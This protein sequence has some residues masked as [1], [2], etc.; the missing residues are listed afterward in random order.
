MGLDLLN[1]ADL[2]RFLCWLKKNLLHA[3]FSLQISIPSF[4][5]YLA[6]LCGLTGSSFF[7]SQRV[8]YIEII[9]GGPSEGARDRVL[10]IT[11]AETSEGGTR[12]CT[13]F[14]W[15]I[16]WRKKA[17]TGAI[18]LTFGGFNNIRRKTS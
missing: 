8:A 9:L 13:F 15:F 3:P 16:F 4:G 14:R 17:K 10:W 12:N 18:T 7:P 1:R 11:R 5:T 6:D 2:T